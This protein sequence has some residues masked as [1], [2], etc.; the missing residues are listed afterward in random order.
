MTIRIKC[1]VE[2][3]GS[4][5]AGYQIQPNALTIQEV[6]ENCL[7]EVLSHPVRV[8]A[9]SR[10]DA[11]VHA[12]GQIIAFDTESHIPPARI[13][14]I[15]NQRLPGSIRMLQSEVVGHSFQP[16]FDA[17]S[18]TYQYL[19]Y[20]QIP[21]AVFWH[22]KAW[23]YTLPLDFAAMQQAA[24]RLVGE[25]DMSCFCASGGVVQDKVRTIYDC[26]WI[27]D[28]P[29]WKF[30]VQGNGFL[31]H[32]VRNMVGTMVEIGRGFW[33]PLYIE[34]LIASK[35]RNQAGP[36]APAAGLYLDKVIY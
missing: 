18:K 35:N 21:G 8:M 14:R 32:Q 11:G 1:L 10:T 23:I 27:Q 4:G 13:A 28:G 33:E 17:Q 12:R 30:T 20:R 16:R 9:A 24:S 3:D 31:Y 26:S 7:A 22:Q 6:L 29:I 2:Y 36:T 19:I 5:Y 15:C 25:Y 34:G